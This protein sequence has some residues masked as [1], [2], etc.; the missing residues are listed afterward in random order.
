MRVL[1]A[2]D[3]P[4]AR[5]LLRAAISKA[6]HEVLEAENGREAIERFESNRLQIDLLILDVVMPDLSGYEVARQIRADHPD[7]VPIIFVSGNA[8]ADDLVEGIR[9][10]GDDYLFKPINT[11]ILKAK[12][13]AMQRIAEMRNQLTDINAQLARQAEQ[14][15]L[16]KLPNRDKCLRDLEQL[17]DQG[18]LKFAVIKIAIKDFRYLNNLFGS[19]LGDEL[20]ICV[21]DIL[22]KIKGDGVG[23]YRATG[24]EFALVAP[25]VET[26]DELAIYCGRL[27]HDFDPPKQFSN[28][29]GRICI[30]LGASLVSEYTQNPESLLQEAQIA[31]TESKGRKIQEYTLF[32]AQMR[33]KRDQFIHVREELREAL[34]R[35]EFEL[36]YQPQVD[37]K[38]KRIQGAEALVRWNHP[39]R[40]LV[41]PLEFIPV[42]EESGLILDL[43]RWVLQQA[44]SQAR[45]WHERGW[46]NFTLGV[47][48]S[49]RHFEYGLVEQDVEVALESTGVL[50]RL[51]ELELTESAVFEDK[52]A[53]LDLLQR[54]NDQGIRLAIDDFG[55]GY[56]N[57]SYLAELPLHKLKIDQSF[58]RGFTSSKKHRILVQTIIMLARTLGLKT[59]A[60][61]VEASDLAST[62]SAL[63]CNAMQGYLVSKP[64]PLESFESLIA[65]QLKSETRFARINQ[66]FHGQ[67]KWSG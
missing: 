60:E 17:W 64:V 11:D 18:N 5:L 29:S 65:D 45:E 54:W 7:W 36:Y 1:I 35:G 49:A 44:F 28:F 46:E 10:G 41:P 51:I 27:L 24:G 32:E 21:R 13:M 9:V 37:L 57:L 22:L 43:T 42:A 3:S 58:V 23:L 25:N 47:N 56:S 16:T 48:L 53:A 38:T 61:G 59:I 15:R 55:T 52:K 4:T 34:N 31:L 67:A 2:D 39:E 33:E 50:P 30:Y 62:L 8:G 14:D 12:I 6:G 20:L 40:G 63:G 19:V 66:C 26:L